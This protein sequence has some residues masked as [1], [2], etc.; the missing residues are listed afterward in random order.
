MVDQTSNTL[1]FL[2]YVG[3]AKRTL[4]TGWV[5]NGVEQVESFA[6]HMYRMGI[7]SLLLSDQNETSKVRCMKMSLV[8]DLEKSIVG[9][10][11]ADKQ[12]KT[13][14][15]RA[16]QSEAFTKLFSLLPDL[17]G[18][19][20]RSLLDEYH[21]QETNEA[22]L[23]RDLDLFDMLLQGSINCHFFSNKLSFFFSL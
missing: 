16:R 10:L 12:V 11:G 15:K 13:K 5:V 23:V 14:E 7:M 4:R 18:Q 19:E 8:H 22:K 17:I 1:Q 6:D 21:S 20:F 9:D 3:Q 2:L